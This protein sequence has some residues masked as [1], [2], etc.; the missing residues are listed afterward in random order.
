M[1]VPRYLSRHLIEEVSERPENGY[2]SPRNPADGQLHVCDIHE[3]NGGEEERRRTGFEGNSNEIFVH[4]ANTRAEPIPR[5]RSG[6]DV[7][8]GLKAQS[9]RK[10]RLR[11]RIGSYTWTCFTMTMATGGIASILH[12]GKQ[13]VTDSSKCCSDM[14]TYSSFQ[15]RMAADPRSCFLHAQ[16]RSL[17]D[18]LLYY[19]PAIS[20][21]SRFFYGFLYEPFRVV[22]H[23]RVCRLYVDID[24]KEAVNRICRWSREFLATP[25]S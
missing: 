16:R 1:S 9:V 3:H 23:H 13:P 2:E 8:T 12:G 10:I 19:Y 11:D 15:I 17:S 25:I 22:I 21:Q 4:G 6:A 18:Q 24:H 20:I 5:V 14:S 7:E